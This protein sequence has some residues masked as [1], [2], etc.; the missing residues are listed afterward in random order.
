MD[1]PLWLPESDPQYAGF[2]A[3]DAGKAVDAGLKYR[4]VTSTVKDTLEW[5]LTR[6]DNYEWRAGLRREREAELLALWK[7]QR[8]RK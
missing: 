4:P 7:H 3:I 6:P 2:F 8:H 5:A 1:L